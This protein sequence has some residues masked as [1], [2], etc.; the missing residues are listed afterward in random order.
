VAKLS[1]KD[2]GV[3][4]DAATSATA[5]IR[6]LARDTFTPSVL[7]E[8]GGFGGLFDG[9]F[10]DMASPVLVSSTDGV[11][12]KLKIAFLT[13]RHDTVGGDLVNHCINDIGVQGA[14]P[15][16]FMDYIAT[17]RLDPDVVVSLVGGV[18]KACQYSGCALIGGETAEMPGF[19]ADGEYDIAG[20]IVGVVDRARLIDGRDIRPGDVLVALPSVGLHTNG[21]SLARKVF[22][23]VA[24]WTVDTDVPELAMTVG[25]QLLKPHPNYEPVLR[26]ALEQGLVLG[27]AHITGGGITD[28]LP[29]ILPE[30]CA[31]EI[32]LGSWPVLPVFDLIARLGDVEGKEMLRATNMGVGMIAVVRPESVGAFSDAMETTHYRIGR[33]VESVGGAPGV[34]YR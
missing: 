21:Y 11:G 1:Y 8:I 24:G 27:L 34:V 3:D 32:E 9:R 2:S 16:F 20:F 17:G 18:A 31:A 14:R 15:L 29:R 10:G 33:V 6:T 23:D 28:N 22:F 7:S 12:T 30:G 13:G 26:P 19:Y 5:R 25:E 4:I